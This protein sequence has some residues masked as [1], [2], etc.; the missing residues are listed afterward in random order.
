MN[1]IEIKNL[2]KKYKNF[3][4]VDSLNLT[5][6]EG[7]FFGLLG[8][9]GAGKTTTIKMLCGLLNLTS[10][11]A[12][13]LGH[14]LVHDS[15]AVKDII[16][17]SPQETAVALHLTVKE[18]LMLVSRLYGADKNLAKQKVNSLI[19][20]FRLKEY[21]NVR[22]KALS[23]G[24]QRKL[25]IAMSL[26]TNPKILFLD[27]PTLGLDVRA[28]RDL[29]NTIKELKG[30]ATIILTTHYLEEAE[31][32]SDRICIMNNGKIQVMGTAQE[33]IKKT[34]AKNFE[35]AFLMNTEEARS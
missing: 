8:S 26:I 13:M 9:N 2:T 12:L 6:P 17:V 18:N 16:N 33:I 4:A 10:G 24:W 11:D 32:L 23:G 21:E 15:E 14:S 34:G 1:A 22:S 27:E 7:E 20:T 25:S 30:K 19:N 31:A 35:E 3:T 29:W 28:R 5:I